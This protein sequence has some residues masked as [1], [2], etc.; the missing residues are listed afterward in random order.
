[1]FAHLASRTMGLSPQTNEITDS[2]V[3]RTVSGG[4]GGGLII[5]NIMSLDIDISNIMFNR[6]RGGLIQLN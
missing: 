6:I 1:M 2:K 3:R 4:G 5:L